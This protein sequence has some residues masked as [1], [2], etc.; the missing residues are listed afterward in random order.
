MRK[1][2]LCLTTYN[3]YELLLE[4]F[5]QVLYDD[6]IA[7]IIISDDCST[8]GSYERLKDFVKNKPKIKLYQNDFNL[9][10]YFN[11]RK[12]ID[13]ATCDWCIIGDSDNVFTKDYLDKIFAIPE[14]DEHTIYQ[15]SFAKPHFDFRKY[16][17]MTFTK[18]NIAEHFDKPMVST[19]LNAM[20]Y[21]VNKYTFEQAWQGNVDPHTADSIFQNYNHLAAGGSIFVVPGLTYEHRVHD[22]SHYKNNVHL[23]GDFYE[24]VENKIRELK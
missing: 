9:D 22:G 23:T 2:A 5:Q 15:P 14:W 16:E 24:D 21:L 13:H 19:M 4:S 3:R 10:C 8:D 7:E 6:R 20:N 17:G 12:A 1:I 11:K 18:K